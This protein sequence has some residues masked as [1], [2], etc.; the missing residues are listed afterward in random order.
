MSVRLKM[1]DFISQKFRNCGGRVAVIY[2]YDQG[3]SGIVKSRTEG[4]V[5]L[6]SYSLRFSC[7]TLLKSVIEPIQRIIVF[8][9]HYEDDS[10]TNRTSNYLIYFF[11]LPLSSFKQQSKSTSHLLVRNLLTLT[12]TPQQRLPYF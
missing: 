11:L 8:N 9:R 1:I 4:Q 6:S 5:L 7:V 2:E 12:L 3:M 10:A